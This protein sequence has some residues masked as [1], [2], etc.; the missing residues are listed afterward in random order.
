MRI[1]LLAFAVG[2]ACGVL[3]FG[4]GMVQ[5]TVNLSGRTFMGTPVLGAPFSAER[6]SEHVQTAAD[7]TRFTTNNRHETIYR[8]SQ[9][10]VRT[11]RTVTMGPT[12]VAG[13]PG[14]VEIQDPVAGFSYALD[15][16]SKVAHRTALH[17]PPTTPPERAM[18]ANAGGGTAARATMGPTSANARPQ[19]DIRQEDLGQQTMEGVIVEGRR[20]VRTWPAGSQGNDRP[21]QV[22]TE[23]WF[24]PELKE[25]ILSRN[26]DPRSGENT[27]RLTN[28][29]RTEP[30]AN[31]FQ[32]PPDY[33]VVE[34]NG[35]FQIHWTA[36]KQ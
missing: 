3:V 5:G 29:S 16:Q 25:T 30:S 33:Q 20:T 12:D 36:T 8:D 22:V 26:T 1:P 31:L 13:A 18:A 23:N 28:V 14:I 4:Q 15:A 24:S 34:E 32:P 35:P 21:F 2:L 11:E 10:R 19:P 27:S 6:V 7:G 17:A 9:G